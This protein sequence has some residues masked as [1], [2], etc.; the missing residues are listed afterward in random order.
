MSK[1][2]IS[3]PFDDSIDRSSLFSLSLFSPL[4]FF[5]FFFPPFSCKKTRIMARIEAKRPWWWVGE[6]HRRRIPSFSSV[7]ERESASKFE[8]SWLEERR[9]A[10]RS[11]L[12]V[13]VWRFNDFR[14]RV[15]DFRFSIFFSFF[16]SFWFFSNLR[17][18][19]VTE[20]YRNEFSLF[21]FLDPGDLLNF[22]SSNKNFHREKSYSREKSPC[23]ETVFQNW[24]S[25]RSIYATRGMISIMKEK[26]GNKFSLISYKWKTIINYIII[27]Q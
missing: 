21:S 22:I 20:F 6:F 5:S 11:L 10:N 1:P 26:G 13:R 16:F 8:T 14:R 25:L 4:F 24:N 18:F 9:C 12:N 23:N 15:E 27:I 17:K 19:K 3:R 2:L 7:L